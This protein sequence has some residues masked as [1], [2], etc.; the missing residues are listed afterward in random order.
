MKKLLLSLFILFAG[1]FVFAWSATY[2]QGDNWAITCANG[3]SWSYS[4]SSAGLEIVGPALCPAGIAAP[5][6]PEGY[7]LKKGILLSGK[8][9]LIKNRK[10]IGDRGIQTRRSYPPH[11]YP[12]L[13]CVPCPGNPTEFCDVNN[14][15]RLLLQ[16]LWTPPRR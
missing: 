1:Q 4:G 12:C 3:T 10:E 16:S 6:L 9:E 13:G 2:L 5:S 14:T 8:F 15:S 11:G 7:N